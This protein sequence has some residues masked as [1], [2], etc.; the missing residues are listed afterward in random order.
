MA[1]SML[2]TEFAHVLGM[3]K[4][5]AQVAKQVNRKGDEP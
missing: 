4:R 2:F 5:R 3:A 1:K